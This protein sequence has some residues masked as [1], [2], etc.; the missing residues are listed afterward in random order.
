VYYMHNIISSS[1][2]YYFISFL[3]YS[4][5]VSD[6]LWELFWNVHGGAKLRGHDMRLWGLELDRMIDCS[7]RELGLIAPRT[8]PDPDSWNRPAPATPPPV[9]TIPPFSYIA[10]FCRRLSPLPRELPPLHSAFDH[11]DPSS[12]ESYSRKWPLLD[13]F[14][15][16][17]D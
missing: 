8:L 5:C 1:L 9:R 7:R 17:E 2:K 3:H 14:L 12:A 15:Y 11:S 16:V 13:I 10:E 4:E 6:K